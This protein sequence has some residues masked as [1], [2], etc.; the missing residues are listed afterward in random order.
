[1]K[2]LA[3]RIKGQPISIRVVESERD[4]PAFEEFVSRHRILGFDTET[5][6]LDWW[7][8]DFRCRLA[9]FGT[10]S[11]T[12]V[13]PVELGPAYA[14]AVRRALKRL[15]WL[16]AH[17]GTFDLHVVEQT[18]GIPMEELAPKMWDTRLLAH[19]VDPRA[20]KERGPGLKL[21]ELTKFYVCEQTADEVKG[22]LTLIAKKYK[23][24]KEKIWKLVELFDPDYLLYAGMD[25]AL[26]YRLFQLL[27]R[28][29]PARSK[30]QGLIGWEHQ[31]AHVTAKLERTGYL[32]DVEYAETRCA[33]LSA[34]QQ[35]WEAVARSFEV[36]N[37][38]S[39]QQLVEAFTRLG[40]KLTKRTKKGQLAMD[41][42]VLT[43]LKHPLADAVIKSRK[44]SKWRKTWFERALNGRDA[45]NRVHAGINSLQARTSRMSISGSIPAQTFPSGDG[46]VRHMFLADEGHV[47]CSIDF[48]NMELRYLAAFSRDKTM[49]DAF[50]NGRDLHQITAD[51][52]GVPRK[53]GKMA[54]FLTVYGGGWAALMEQASVDEETA[55]AVLDAFAATYPGV[56]AFGRRLAD[57]AR[58]T[59][60]VW[61]ATGRRLPVD[62]GK[63]FRA[64]N[65]FI[66]GGSR[67]V[68]ARA[69]LKLDA[70]GFTPY[71]RL[72][73][74]DEIVFSFP[75]KEAPEMA[76]EAA[77]LMEFPV[78]GLLIP[79]DSEIGGRSWGSVLELEESKH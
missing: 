18:L 17:N 46:Y 67:D 20:V 39:N 37:P 55:R 19:L 12:W 3:Y 69:L 76:R 14:E 15:E 66:Q 32:L 50:L 6:G 29:V 16:V 8:P 53:V 13:I 28:L 79:A 25:P 78:Q 5:T 52:A 65:Y 1:M 33:E 59:G 41:D 57:E 36:E 77:R 64:L 11:E 44:A 75:E 48:G 47:S 43:S 63:W 51:A 31:L 62:P 24:T 4:L 21:E 74:H 2:Q 72:P 60:Y 42:D 58:R 71:M 40:V 27:Y 10:G 30:A 9:Q 73:I 22:S 26:A 54:N 68:T 49:L 70:A 23:T 35:E 34:E 38:N 45:N 56:G 7:A 61:T